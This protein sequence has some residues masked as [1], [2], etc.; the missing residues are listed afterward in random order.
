MD[1]TH[2]GLHG[3]E[4]MRAELDQR[5]EQRFFAWGPYLYEELERVEPA[6]EMRLIEAGEIQATGFR[7]V[8]ELRPSSPGAR[9]S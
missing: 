4:T 7:F 5:F 3:Y 1:D 8:G 2:E 6:E 9:H